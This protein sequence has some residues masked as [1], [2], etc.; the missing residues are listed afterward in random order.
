MPP[1]RVYIHALTPS[2]LL[3]SLYL[4]LELSYLFNASRVVQ[5]LMLRLDTQLKESEKIN[6]SIWFCCMTKMRGPQLEKIC[7]GFQIFV[8]FQDFKDFVARF[9]DFRAKKNYVIF[10]IKHLV[11]EDLR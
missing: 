10:K 6:T 3:L 4:A 8:I 2:F 1:G 5:A 9:Q 7:T 11:S